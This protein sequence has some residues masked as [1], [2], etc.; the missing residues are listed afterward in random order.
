[1]ILLQ[2]I[3]IYWYDLA[4][5]GTKK[6]AGKSSPVKYPPVMN[7]IVGFKQVLNHIAEEQKVNPL[8]HPLSHTH[9]PLD[10]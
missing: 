9:I 7:W 5:Y 3:I 4:K 10:L 6:W 2:F 1:M 8:T